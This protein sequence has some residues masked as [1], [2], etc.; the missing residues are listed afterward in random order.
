MTSFSYSSGSE[1][2]TSWGSN[3][4]PTVRSNGFFCRN[5]NGRVNCEAW[6]DPVLPLPPK[7]IFRPHIMDGPDFVGNNFNNFGSTFFV[8]NFPK[9]APQVNFYNLP[10]QAPLVNNNFINLPV[11][12]PPRPAFQPQQVN[13]DFNMMRACPQ[14]MQRP[15]QVKYAPVIKINN[16]HHKNDRRES[17][18]LKLIGN[19]I[20]C[21]SRL[22]KK[23]AEAAPE[24]RG[25]LI[26]NLCDYSPE[27]IAEETAGLSDELK[28]QI[29]KAAKD[30][31][32]NKKGA[33]TKVVQDPK[34]LAQI[35]EDDKKIKNLEAA[36][37]GVQDENAKLIAHDA[38]QDK[39]I[40]AQDGEI[41]KQTGQINVLD[42]KVTEQEK[43]AAAR[44]KQLDELNTKAEGMKTSLA[45]ANAKATLASTTASDASK[46]AGDLNTS[47][48]GLNNE[49]TTSVKPSVQRNTESISNQG[50]LIQV[51]QGA[52][53]GLKTKIDDLTRTVEDLAAKV[54]GTK[55][56]VGDL[57]KR[58]SEFS[59]EINSGDSSV[60]TDSNKLSTLWSKLDTLKEEAKI[61]PAELAKLDAPNEVL[62]NLEGLKAKYDEISSLEAEVEKI[63][64][65]PPTAAAERTT[66]GKKIEDLSKAVGD[67]I[68]VL[69]K[70]VDEK[71]IPESYDK[72]FGQIVKE[73]TDLLGKEATEALKKSSSSSAS[74][75][76]A[77]APAVEPPAAPPVFP[78][79]TVDAAMTVEVNDFV[80]KVHVLETK[81][82]ALDATIFDGTALADLGTERA[83]LSM[84]VST[85]SALAA[86]ALDANAKLT[87]IGTGLAALSRIKTEYDKVNASIISLDSSVSQYKAVPDV[88]K[89]YLKGNVDSNIIALPLAFI[90]FETAF[91][92]SK[93]N[94]P[95][96]CASVYDTMKL[97]ADVAIADA[98][99]TV[100]TGAP[101]SPSGPGALTV[102][103]ALDAELKAIKTTPT[104]L[105][106]PYA[107]IDAL[108]KIAT[109]KG[110]ATA[111]NTE[112]TKAIEA[113][114]D[115]V[116][117][118]AKDVFKVSIDSYDAKKPA[119]KPALTMQIAIDAFYLRA[120][121]KGVD[122]SFGS[123]VDSILADLKAREDYNATLA[124]SAGT[125][126]KILQDAKYKVGSLGVDTL[127]QLK[128]KAGV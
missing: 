5:D 65:N 13:I 39:V 12:L 45:D 60:F 22:S 82:N 59:D 3:Q 25:D 114:V 46:K 31:L 26:I 7:D 49:I 51:A 91:N 14:P 24:E 80:S 92:N 117:K 6:G 90:A 98:A 35:A 40:T 10:K 104:D 81:F 17:A 106:N 94:I 16:E 100:G 93:A 118:V 69:K 11:P 36:L 97:K 124:S 20:K 78:L 33:V 88:I 107:C 115:E 18:F 123:K 55:P 30:L 21:N 66:A 110:K 42:G 34:L 83:V 44:Q 57:S 23:L 79:P 62:R 108:V 41:K 87:K 61:N 113:K 105:T 9:Q 64:D 102:T 74:S 76:S 119:D 99:T 103:P 58:I 121:L 111:G 37:K 109:A 8:N 128:A 56:P 48:T 95:S 72:G 89:P 116:V 1:F 77:P 120:A 75:P 70:D 73:R 29:A 38:E 32:A 47:L 52:I 2:S 63:R 19:L 86:K 15:I 4:M 125:L 54:G 27:E 68:S 28:G 122:D 50:S 126:K 85:D 96:G 84:P 112:D 101:V 71:K 53:E 43:F 127:D 67:F